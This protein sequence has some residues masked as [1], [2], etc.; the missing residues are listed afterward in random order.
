[1]KR[2][3]LIEAQ[4]KAEHGKFREHNNP[5]FA[6][7]AY[8]LCRRKKL[9]IPEWVLEYFDNTASNLI[10]LDSETRPNDLLRALGLVKPGA[11]TAV[12]K[13]QR[14]LKNWMIA[15]HVANEL[16]KGM[17]LDS[18]YISVTEEL[19]GSKIFNNPSYSTVRRAFVQHIDEF[20]SFGIIDERMA[21]QKRSTGTPS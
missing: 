6:W 16:N 17:P 15:T 21:P 3:D 9:P 10:M 7:D 14:V 12:S 4:L 8:I 2:K 19:R 13:R 18:A 20:L 11:G 1:M 5:L